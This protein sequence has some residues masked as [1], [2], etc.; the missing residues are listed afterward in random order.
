MIK[1]LADPDTPEHPFNAH[2][3]STDWPAVS[4]CFSA[5]EVRKVLRSRREIEVETF[6]S[7]YLTEQV[8]VVDLLSGA[9]DG[10]TFDHQLGLAY[11]HQVIFPYLEDDLLQACFRFDPRQ[12]FYWGGRIKPIVKQILET[13]TTSNVTRQRKRGGGFQATLFAWMRDGVLREMVS[14]ISRPGFLSREEYDRCLR[15]PN[16]FT[17]NL[18][19]YDLFEKNVVNQLDA[20]VP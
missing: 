11:G 7:D 19:T 20:G 2:F 14:D 1:V 13:H 9:Y 10:A 15:A 3:V 6:G 4:R 18:L 12:R 8:Q 17:W 5:T 16:L